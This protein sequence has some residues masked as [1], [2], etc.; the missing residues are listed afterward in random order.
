MMARPPG[1]TGHF[2]EP[3]TCSIPINV[4]GDYS[5]SD[6]DQRHRFVGSVV[7]QP[8]YAQNMSS[9]FAKQLLD[10]WDVWH[11]DRRHRSA[12]S[13]VPRHLRLRHGGIDGGLTG[14]EVSTFAS[15]VGGTS[16]LAGRATAI[17]CLTWSN[18]DF[19]FGRGFT[20]HEKY[21]L[22]FRR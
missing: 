12:L 3:T 17:T 5:Y 8:M 10:G 2:S 1:R 15:A 9:E 11:S 18:I 16:I 20:I 19:R 21:R 14:G 13:G 22:D 6:L 7:W 4:Q